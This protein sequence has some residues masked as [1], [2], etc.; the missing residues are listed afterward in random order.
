M[1]ANDS[2]RILTW[3]CRGLG[4]PST[5]SQLKESIRLNS[6][7]LVFVCETKQPKKF[8]ETV[9]RKLKFGNKCET[10]EPVG[11]KDG[12]LVAWRQGVDV[13]QIWKSKF[14]MEMLVEN[15]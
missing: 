4:G 7:D 3:N 13:K 15:C 2:M 12:L 5:I 11:R 9:C 14:C 1:A 6:P 8:V 10:Y